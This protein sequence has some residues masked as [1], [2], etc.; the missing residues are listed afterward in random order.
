M[1][2][3]LAWA[4]CN[5]AGLKLFSIH[6]IKFVAV[7]VVLTSWWNVSPLR[8]PGGNTAPFEEMTQRWRAVGNT[9][10]DLT[11]PRFEPRTSCSRD[12]PVTAQPSGMFDL[13]FCD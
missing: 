5:S 6:Q 9:L 3:M 4:K 10:F 7:F 8:S 2:N 13:P 1:G 12:K 11:G